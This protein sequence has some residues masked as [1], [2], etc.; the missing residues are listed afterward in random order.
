MS[1]SE[2]TL[3]L[4]DMLAGSGCTPRTV[5][6]YEREGLL[7]ATRT[8]GGHRAFS[9]E[10][11]D[12]LNFIVALREAGW[13]LE[14]IAELLAVRGTA[15]SDREA[16]RRIDQTLHARLGELERKLDL[17]TR[18]RSDLE[19]TRKALA[20]CS[21]CTQESPDRARCLGCTRLPEPAELPRGFRLTWRI[22]G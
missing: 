14:E 10:E 6:F 22:D 11:L 5:R 20:V 15:A 16:C 1:G 8:R 12:R 9:P 21:E 19:G 4:K 18:L 17:L 13:S 7:R 2:R 3:S